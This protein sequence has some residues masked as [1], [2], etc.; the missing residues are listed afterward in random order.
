M[1]LTFLAGYVV[2]QHG[3]QSARLAA[4]AGAAGGADIDDIYD[5]HERVDRLILALDAM[6]SLLEDSGYSAEELNARI[7][8]IDAADGLIDGK[9]TAQAGQCAECGA[10]VA[11]GLSACQFCGARVTGAA[12][13]PFAGL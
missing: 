4:T 12:P 11:A 2:G 10:K 6:W 1:G 8:E 7:Q 13:D 9:R 5:L 3:R